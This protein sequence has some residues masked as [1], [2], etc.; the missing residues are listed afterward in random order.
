MRHLTAIFLTLIFLM[1]VSIAM[2]AQEVKDAAIVDYDMIHDDKVCTI[3][4]DRDV[5]TDGSTEK[6]T[7]RAFSWK[8]LNDDYLW[9][10][11]LHIHKNQ[12]PI[13][14]RYSSEECFDDSIKN[15]KLL[16]VW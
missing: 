2:A 9:H 7:P 14:I 13:D 10:M 16:T 6:C 8:C 11:V 4:I 12:L 3:T 15:L 5:Q 1:I